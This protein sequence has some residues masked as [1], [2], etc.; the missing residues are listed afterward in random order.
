MSKSWSPAFTCDRK[1][2]ENLKIGLVRYLIVAV[3]VLLAFRPD[4][5]SPDYLFHDALALLD[6]IVEGRGFLVSSRFAAVLQAF[7]ALQG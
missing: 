2:E 6:N 3:N 4:E 7:L 5:R 1:A